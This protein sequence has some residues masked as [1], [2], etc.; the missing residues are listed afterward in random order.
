MVIRARK[1]NP[2]AAYGKHTPE[3]IEKR[4][5]ERVHDL[6]EAFL[7]EHFAGHNTEIMGA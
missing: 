3:W 1:A 7:R 4:V 6:S 2:N 5:I